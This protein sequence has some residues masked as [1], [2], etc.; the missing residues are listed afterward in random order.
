MTQLLL[1]ALEES[2]H[3][4]FP[5]LGILFPSPP[6]VSSSNDV[7]SVRSSLL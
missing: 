2:F 6:S 7:V 1:R 5:L 4:M 3:W